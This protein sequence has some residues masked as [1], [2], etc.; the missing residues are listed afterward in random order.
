MK[1][2]TTNLRPNKEVRKPI[3][4]IILLRINYEEK[5]SCFKWSWD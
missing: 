1:Y 4:P 2:N 5:F 3:K